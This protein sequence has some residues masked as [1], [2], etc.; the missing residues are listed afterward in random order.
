MSG[1]HS[2]WRSGTGVKVHPLG[3]CT[4][5]WGRCPIGEDGWPLVLP[6]PAVGAPQFLC[7]R[8]LARRSASFVRPHPSRSL[9]LVP[10]VAVCL[11]AGLAGVLLAEVRLGLVVRSGGV[12]LPLGGVLLGVGVLYLGGGCPRWVLVYLWG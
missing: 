1:V 2:G 7:A 8:R 6:V 11:C 9:S 10:F 5:V 3:G 4:S 12:R